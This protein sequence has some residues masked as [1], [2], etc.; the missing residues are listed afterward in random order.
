MIGLTFGRLTVLERTQD[1]SLSSKHGKPILWLCECACGKTKIVSGIALRKGNVKSCGCLQ[2]EFRLSQHGLNSPGYIDGRCCD[3]QKFYAG[4]R[5]RAEYKCQY[6]GV[7]Q[8][9]LNR[10]LDVHH[11]D[12]IHENN[13]FENAIALCHSCHQQQHV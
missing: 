6:C 7:T 9:I 1:Y 3:V 10:K 2:Q 12:G 13:V 5:R 4:V 11:L 8:V